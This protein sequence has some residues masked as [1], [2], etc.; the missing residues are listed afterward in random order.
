MNVHWRDPSTA[1]DTTSS[2]E[3]VREFLKHH[4]N[5]GRLALIQ[6]TSPFIGVQYLRQAVKK[7][8]KKLCVFSA[9][10][11]Y[12]L[13]WARDKK[14]GKILPI[15]FD[16]KKRPRRQDCDGKQIRSVANFFI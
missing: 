13:R 5:V 2:I 3:S 1:L 6:C 16:F 7:F 9:V 15:N 14:S 11:S 4:Q 8:K 12:K 10:K